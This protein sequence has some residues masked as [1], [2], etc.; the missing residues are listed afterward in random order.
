M[1]REERDRIWPKNQNAHV[2]D[3][4]TNVPA[5]VRFDFD[6]AAAERQRA[7][8]AAAERE[9]DAAAYRER[10]ERN[11]RGAVERERFRQWFAAY[12]RRLM[13]S[14]RKDIGL[15]DTVI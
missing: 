12:S 5:S 9:K 1:T 13:A 2:L 10:Y 11:N 4:M 14:F 6:R 3:F 8:D 7:Y 15:C